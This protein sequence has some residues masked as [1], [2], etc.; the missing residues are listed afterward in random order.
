MKI[1]SLVFFFALYVCVK[2][3]SDSDPNLVTTCN[4]YNP[5]FGCDPQFW[6]GGDRLQ[7]LNTTNIMSWASKPVR[8]DCF[9]IIAGD[10]NSPSNTYV[11]GELITINIRVSCFK[12]W[13][14]GIMLVKLTN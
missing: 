11:P 9:E 6:K 5:L 10:E 4:V 7:C 2:G 8:S 3:V 12:M 13:Y 1:I 14:R